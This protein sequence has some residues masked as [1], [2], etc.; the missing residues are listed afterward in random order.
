MFAPTCPS[1]LLQD[2]AKVHSEGAAIC[3]VRALVLLEVR[4]YGLAILQRGRQDLALELIRHLRGWCCL[5]F[6]PGLLCGID[7]L[8][9]ELQPLPHV[10]EALNQGFHFD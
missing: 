7:K 5:C 3:R 10:L 6:L 9:R 8:L 2:G 4:A 1:R